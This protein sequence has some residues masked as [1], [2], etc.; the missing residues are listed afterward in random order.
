MCGIAGI[1]KHTQSDP[2][3]IVSEMIGAIRYRGPDDWGMWCDPS[4]GLG[5]GHTRL[6]ILDLSSAGHQPMQSSSGRYVIVFNG[7]IYNHLELREQI[8]GLAWCG[9]SDTETLLAAFES[10]GVEKTLQATVGMF[11]LVLWDRV[12]RRLILARD[13][14]G[15]K[16]FYY[17]CPMGRFFLPLS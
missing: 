8:C 16:P 3:R 11:A 9:H 13:R 17:G 5:L 1:F 12:K 4:I 15:E 10:W 14:I 6:S 7:E 2:S